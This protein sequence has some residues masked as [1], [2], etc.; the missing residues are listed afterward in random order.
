MPQSSH[1]PARAEPPLL[2]HGRMQSPLRRR[3]SLW[4]FAATLT[5]TLPG[6]RSQETG[7][8]HETAAHTSAAATPEAFLTPEA[9]ARCVDSFLKPYLSAGAATPFPDTSNDLER[10][11][12]GQ[13]N[14]TTSAV[15]A[16]SAQADSAAPEKDTLWEFNRALGPR[17]TPANCPKIKDFIDVA[18]TDAKR[19]NSTIK[20]R[21]NRPR[22]GETD[23]AHP[24]MNPSFPSGHS[25]TAGLRYRLL[26]AITDAPPDAEIELFKQAWFMCFQRLAVNVHY[27]SDISAGFVLG[28]MVADEVLKQ[29]AAE[30]DG[31]AGRALAAAK[32]QWKSLRE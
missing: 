24:K 18:F 8:P 5:L 16:T 29:A 23:P 30:P 17:F 11:I 19:V 4:F 10:F 14:A 1:R 25:T 7:S 20:K 15:I 27:S 26:T 6:C 22:P 12:N 3:S 31:N 21:F 13:I 28:E 2:Y 32:Q 9:A